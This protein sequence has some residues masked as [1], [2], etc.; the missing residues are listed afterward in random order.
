MRNVSTKIQ[1]I[2]T[3]SEYKNGTHKV[4][5]WIDDGDASFAESFSPL[6]LMVESFKY[7]PLGIRIRVTM[8][9]VN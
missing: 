9:E 7:R 4:N 1:K 6:H 8:E 3:L 5:G 2:F